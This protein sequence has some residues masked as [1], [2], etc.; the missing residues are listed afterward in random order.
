MIGPF[1]SDVPVSSITSSPAG[2]LIPPIF[3]YSGSYS[4]SD[5][6]YPGVGYWAMVDQSGTLNL[7]AVTAAA[8]STR[9]TSKLAKTMPSDQPIPTLATSSTC[10]EI[11]DLDLSVTDGI[12]NQ[13]LTIGQGNFATISNDPGCDLLA[14]PPA[15]S[16][17]FDV[18]I[19]NLTDYFIDYRQ[20]DYADQIIWD[21]NYTPSSGNGP[22]IL[23]WN[24]LAMPGAGSF[25]LMDRFGGMNVNIDMA[26]TDTF[27]SSTSL[28]TANGVRIVYDTNQII[29][30][31]GSSDRYREFDIT[32]GGDFGL[33]TVRIMGKE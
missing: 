6:L 31:S 28:F 30:Q 10:Y 26:S 32:S 33:P 17:S 14:P 19:A 20:A 29:G 21:I 11:W 22:V 3:G 24:N 25:R 8:M 23:T 12:I 2:L 13:D 27:D 5:T 7:N 1:E 9:A 18:R 4:V 16:G 15:P